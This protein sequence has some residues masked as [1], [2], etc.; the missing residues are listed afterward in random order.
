[1]IE[2]P[3]AKRAKGNATIPRLFDEIDRAFK[4]TSLI[5]MHTDNHDED[6]YDDY[7]DIMNI[8]LTTTMLMLIM[9]RS[10][11]HHAVPGVAWLLDAGL[12]HPRHPLRAV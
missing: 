2:W 4:M 5:P 9:Q 12:P 11:L 6:D 3:R 8:I 7:D 1:M 10:A